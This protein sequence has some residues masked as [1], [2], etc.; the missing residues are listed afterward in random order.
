MGIPRRLLVANL[1]ITL[2]TEIAP[3]SVAPWAFRDVCA[4]N[5]VSHKIRVT[6]DVLEI[7]DLPHLVIA[8]RDIA[9]VCA[10]GRAY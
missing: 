10:Q 9:Y 1:S 6:C 4:G 7:T 5:E 2:V 8:Q 3:P